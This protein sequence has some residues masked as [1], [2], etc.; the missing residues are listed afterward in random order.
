M[1]DFRIRKLTELGVSGE[2]ARP[3]AF[4]DV[5]YTRYPRPGSGERFATR[6]SHMNLDFCGHLNN[7]E[8]IRLLLGTYPGEFQAGH[9][10]RRIEL[11]YL[12][13][14]REGDD[15]LIRRE[16]LPE[17]DCAVICRGDSILV[18]ALLNWEPCQ[19]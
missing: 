3:G 1:S 17:G 8:S 7:V 13:Q 16:T 4:E 19:A 15:L 9:A 11:R 14:G 6:V 10:L 12:Q 18:H 2:M 5:S